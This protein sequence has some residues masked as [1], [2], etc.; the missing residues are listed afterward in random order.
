MAKYDPRTDIPALTGKVAL[1]TGGNRGIG[2]HITLELARHG[3]T[4]Y[5]A[6]RSEAAAL[7]A[8]RRMEA[9]AP[10]L[11][12]QGR[13]RFLHL[14][15]STVRGA[16]EA[17]EQFTRLEKELHI[18]VHNAG[19]LPH[20]YT[21][22]P[23]GLE[24][25]MVVNHL[26]P[27]AFTRVLLPMLYETSKSADV[28]VIVQASRR[29]KE[30]HPGGKFFTAD[31]INDPL[32]SSTDSNSAKLLRY[33]RSKLANVL[34]A[35]GLQEH[36]RRAG[37]SALAIAVNPGDVATQTLLDAVRPIPLLGSL[38]VASFRALLL[39]SSQG[40][41][42]ALFAAT[43]KQVRRD[44]QAYPGAYLARFAKPERLAG[45]A[46]DDAM[47]ERFWDA[48]ERICDDVLIRSL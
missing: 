17:A 19:L 12:G 47:V 8:V 7:D 15:L 3:A 4:V 1:V 23:D 38:A 6:A 42:T 32:G 45:D 10:E 5:L 11:E 22:G 21:R 20:A 34:F 43:S 36:F 28:R 31:E 29:Y 33:A 24:D 39:S 27:F 18:L 2:Y 40:A 35:R 14:D 30:A 16:R 13:L 9:D 26:A 46:A 25:T 37:C 41:H 44:E 48:S